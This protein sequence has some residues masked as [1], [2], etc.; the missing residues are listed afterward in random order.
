[1][2]PLPD[3]VSTSLKINTWYLIS[4]IWYFVVNIWLVF[5]I[6]HLVS[7]PRLPWLLCF[8]STSVKIN[9]VSG[10]NYLG[11]VSPV[12]ATGWVRVKKWV[13]ISTPSK[14][15]FLS[16]IINTGLGQVHYSD[17]GS[18]RTPGGVWGALGGFGGVCQPQN[19][20]YCSVTNLSP[21]M[22]CFGLKQLVT[23]CFWCFGSNGAHLGQKKAVLGPNRVCKKVDFSQK[24]H[25]QI[26]PNRTKGAL[27]SQ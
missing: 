9:R 14:I 7:N 17:F 10:G 15:I 3:F 20:H 8:V 23:L 4:F 21:G 6:Q 2:S 1:M 12:S 11:L 5:N 16:L 19:C 13:K 27:L 22:Q 18:P 25:L 24:H 26:C